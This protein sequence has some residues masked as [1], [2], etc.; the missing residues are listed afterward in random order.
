[1]N[2]TIWK[3]TLSPTT[4]IKMPEG[5]EILDIQTQ[6]GEPQMWALVNP[7]APLEKRT[8]NTHGTGHKMDSHPGKFV[9]TFQVNGGSLVFHVFEA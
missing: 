7:S 6:H 1:M 8:F 3:W 4:E 5:A 9:G 2:F